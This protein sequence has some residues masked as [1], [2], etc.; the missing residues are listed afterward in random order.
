M[1]AFFRRDGADVFLHARVTP[2]ARKD[3]IGG[4]WRGPD[5]AAR[6]A[7]RVA[8]PADEGR[9]NTACRRL[10]AAALALPLAQIQL[11]AG[12]TARLKT[13]RLSG[14]AATIEKALALLSGL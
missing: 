7:L 11:V 8:A 9:A 5:G 6:L 13:F 3:A 12:E 14:D 2:H 10:L 1:S 4:L